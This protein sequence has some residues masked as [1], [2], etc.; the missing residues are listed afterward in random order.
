MSALLQSMSLIFKLIFVQNSVTGNFRLIS[1][2]KKVLRNGK[3]FFTTENDVVDEVWKEKLKSH[4]HCIQLDDFQ[5]NIN[6]FFLLNFHHH[7]AT[8]LLYIINSPSGADGDDC[9]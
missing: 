5:G 6:R 3:V 4:A 8:L 7:Q 9:Y 2:N 1:N